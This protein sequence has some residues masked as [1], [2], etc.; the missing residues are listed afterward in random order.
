MSLAKVYVVAG[1]IDAKLSAKIAPLQANPD[2]GE[3]RLIRRRPF[4]GPK[5][6]CYAPPAWIC[7]V[8]PLAE[9]WRLLTLL[10]LCL[11]QRPQALVAFGT[12]PHGVYC[13]LVGA[14]LGIPVVQHVMGKNDLRLTFPGQRGRRL[15]LAAVRAADLVAVRGT[16]MAKWLIGKGVPAERIFV[17]QNVHDFTLFSPGESA[18]ADHDF[19]YVGLLSL[20]KRIELMLQAFAQVVHERP[21]SRLLLVGDGPE[22]NRLRGLVKK[23]GVTSQVTFA[24]SIPFH[25]TPA[26]LVRGRIFVMTSQG[27]GLPQAMIEAMSCGLPVVVAADADIGDIAKQHENGVLVQEQSAEAYA[28]AMLSLLENEELLEKLR[29]GA[30]KIREQYAVCYSIDFQN[31]LWRQHLRQLR[32]WIASR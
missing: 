9:G 28:K 18:R 27:E 7:R 8:L 16:G 29:Q 21:Q 23:L 22:R 12:V 32:G 15:T 3:I 1:M 10:L 2:I 17:P 31:A 13:W 4:V 30:L 6:I 24:G 19:V 25:E 20:Y 11:F 26:W 5:I 14:L